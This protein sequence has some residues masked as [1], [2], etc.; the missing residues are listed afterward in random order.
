MNRKELLEKTL[1]CIRC[2][3][4]RG[5]TQERVPDIAFTT[6][7]PCGMTFHG[8]YEPA[9]LI[10]CA[11]GIAQETLTW[12]EDLTRVL[13]ACTLCGYCEDLC[14]RSIRYTPVIEIIEE[15]RRIVPNELKPKSL[16]KAA[17]AVKVPKKHKLTVLKQFGIHDVLES[18]NTDTI[19]FPDNM[20]LSHTSKLKEI[21]YILQKSSQQVGCFIS[22]PLPLVGTALINGGHQEKLEKCTT[23]IDAKLSQHG[24]NKV[25]VYN[26]ECLSVLKRF[27]RSGA[28]FISII[29]FYAD[30]LKRMKGKRVNLPPV[31]YQDPC[32]LGRYA[33]EYAAS[34]KVMTTLGLTVK[35]MWRS[36]ENALCCGAGGGVFQ[37]ATRL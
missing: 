22:D 4:C 3:R 6:Q 11:R 10:Y 26:P 25:I 5:V 12:S 32:H 24:I 15:L 2:G 21:G 8:A 9:G 30:M 13:Y 28:E 31:T 20:L 29:R 35:E 14:Q 17:D 23:E 33:K 7:C 19:F 27:S 34:R 1:Y 37:K 36:R 16:K 18:S